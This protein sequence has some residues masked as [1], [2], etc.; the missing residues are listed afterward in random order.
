M[1]EEISLMSLE[2]EKNLKEEAHIVERARRD[3]NAF[4][5]LYRRYVQPVYR[6]LAQRTGDLAEAEDLTSQVFME[7]LEGLIHYCDRGKF[8]AWL[9]TIARRR[10]ID[11]YRK[12]RPSI[13]IDHSRPGDDDKFEAEEWPHLAAESDL[14]GQVERKE[15]L[16]RVKE[17]IEL[18][19]EDRQEI[20]RLRYAAELSYEEMASV[21]KR[22]PASIKMAVHRLLEQ[23]QQS[24]QAVNVDPQDLPDDHGGVSHE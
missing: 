11:F 2:R 20:L 19:P 14:L 15:T 9:F 13:S 6:Y 22:S 24:W 3:A 5:L 16:K 18:L 10:L 7:A 17:L 12:K 4:A 23:L 1:A 8:A 21:L